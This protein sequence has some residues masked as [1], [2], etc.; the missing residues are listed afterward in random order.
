MTFGPTCYSD[1]G[2][3]PSV[4]SESP[5]AKKCAACPHNQWG[6][7]ITD[8]GGKG[9]LCGDSI[10]VAIAPTDQIDDPMLLRIPAA[11]LKAVG[12]YGA[13]LARRGVEPHHV[14]TKIGFERGVA[15]PSLT[16]KAV[17][18]VEEEELKEIEE[19]LQSEAELLGKITG[20][21]ENLSNTEDL[22]QIEEET[23]EK[24]EKPKKAEAKKK[25]PEPEPDEGAEIDEIDDALDDL[26][27]DD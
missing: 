10:R 14:V 16:F 27:W 5:Q 22:V 18:Y 13:T 7:K 26:D 2:I 3:G 15:Y 20:V 17:R 4:N 12:Q 9:K 6:S 21:I 19:V 1:D 8:S 25:K 23:P 11:S 24:E